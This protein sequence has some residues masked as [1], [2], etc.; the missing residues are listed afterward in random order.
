MTYVWK[1][2]DKYRVCVCRR[3][4]V[5]GFY[6]VCIIYVG[7]TT[8]DLS[9]CLAVGLSAEACQQFYII[10][11]QMHHLIWNYKRK[12]K[13]TDRAQVPTQPTRRAWRWNRTQKRLFMRHTGDRQRDWRELAGNLAALYGNIHSPP[14]PPP[15]SRDCIIVIHVVLDNKSKV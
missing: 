1:P 12:H 6:T 7:A 8:V 10:K 9:V 3:Q 15:S 11:C 4:C 2:K 5:V 14:P 13:T